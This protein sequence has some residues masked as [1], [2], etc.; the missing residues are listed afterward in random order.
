MS[1]GGFGETRP[2]TYGSQ[3]SGIVGVSYGHPSSRY[4]YGGK[5]YCLFHQ[6]IARVTGQV[7]FIF[8]QVDTKSI[9]FF[10]PLTVPNFAHEN[11]YEKYSLF[12]TMSPL[13]YYGIQFQSGIL[14]SVI[15]S[16]CD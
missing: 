1:R 3:S 9:R 10:K 5:I 12:E 15:K 2:P 16:I 8:H 14:I 11:A 4:Q 6:V 13:E 7:A